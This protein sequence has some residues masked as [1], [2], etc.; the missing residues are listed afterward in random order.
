M[1]QRTF[2]P[3]EDFFYSKAIKLLFFFLATFLF[4]PNFLQIFPTDT[5]PWYLLI[6]MAT[7]VLSCINQKNKI[8][9]L[10]C[11]FV[12]IMILTL[13]RFSLGF[14][15]QLTKFFPSLFF[16]VFILFLD[17][18]KIRFFLD[19]AFK[20]LMIHIIFGTLVYFILPS[21]YVLLYSA[22]P[23]VIN[24]VASFTLRSLQFCFPEPAYAAKI[25]VLTGISLILAFG[26]E[27]LNHARILFL[28][29]ICTLSLTG[30]FIGMAAM[31]YSLKPKSKIIF[32]LIIA[33]SVFLLIND[34]FILPARLYEIQILL[35]N[36][37]IGVLINDV[38]LQTRLVGLN[39]MAQ[40]LQEFNIF[41]IQFT[42]NSISFL[43]FHQFGALGLVFLLSILFL[44]ILRVLMFDIFIVF[45]LLSVGY[46]DTFI[47]AP[48][49]FLFSLLIRKTYIDVVKI[50]A[51]IAFYRNY[52]LV[53]LK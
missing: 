9:N 4:V 26:E 23:D 48:M 15:D 7:T 42:S 8:R 16:I 14:N 31:A 32:L 13:S 44:I 34:Y 45:I 36:M 46:S 29:S 47:F 30:L 41:G 21:L 37:D 38:S 22:R 25:L 35:K 43:L 33:L 6:L 3:R 28:L 20:T 11:C 1:Q 2:S 12:V 51:K 52:Y 40:N 49:I 10:F 50:F 18:E 27:K 53:N 17:S 5:Q 24:E 39:L 19:L